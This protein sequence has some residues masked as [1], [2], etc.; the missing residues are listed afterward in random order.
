MRTRTLASALAP[1]PIDQMYQS[2]LALLITALTFFS[3]GSGYQTSS[4]R[5]RGWRPGT[6]RGLTVGKSTRADMLRTLGPP[7]SSSPAADQDPPQPII[8]N[9]YG[10]IHGDLSGQLAVEVDSRDN[11]IVSIS[12]APKH[13]SKADAIKYFG[14]DYSLMGYESCP[15]QAP[16]A[17]VGFVYEN[18]KSADIDYL[19]YRARGIAIHL[20]YQG[21]VDAIY[22]VNEPIGLGSKAECKRVTQRSVRLKR[23]R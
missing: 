6:Y 18:P 2:T 21:N 3:S 7:L 19:E 11:K 23:R 17:D 1:A 22:F 15:G 20:D 16:E 10:T 9:D 12:V 13:M 14:K 5:N 4:S 8:W